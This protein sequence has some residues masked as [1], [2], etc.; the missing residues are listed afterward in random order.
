M[1]A[2]LAKYGLI[3]LFFGAGLEGEFAV[4]TGGILARHGSFSLGAAMIVATAGSFFVDQ[5]WYFLGRYARN[6]RFVTRVKSKRLF[7]RAL[8]LLERRPVPFILGF[9]FVYGMRTVSPVAI[10]VAGVPVSKFVPLNLIAAIIWAPLF[11]WLGHKVGKAILPLLHRIGEY[12]LAVLVA[13]L[14]LGP[15]IWWLIRRRRETQVD[16][17]QL[18]A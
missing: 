14:I 15:L 4:V 7:A 9:R 12:G 17:P 18:P 11:T 5:C 8:D 6:S 16:E 10:G 3:V 13:A 1:D 2:L